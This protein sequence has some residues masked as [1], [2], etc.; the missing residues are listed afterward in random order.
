[1]ERLKRS[2][3]DAFPNNF[4][5]RV[6]PFKLIDPSRPGHRKILALFLV[7]PNI[8]PIPST[9]IIPPQQKEWA[10]KAIVACSANPQ[11]LLS[12]LPAELV[13]KITSK[14]DMM[15]DIEAKRIRLEVMEER[16]NEEIAEGHNPFDRYFDLCEH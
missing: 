11:S 5:H 15:D 12:K 9:S 7:D 8:E 4:Q 2:K 1:M 10:T 13:H 14:L 6:S 3:I 16:S